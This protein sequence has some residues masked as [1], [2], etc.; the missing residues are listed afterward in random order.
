MGGSPSY[1]LPSLKRFEE[2]SETSM[3]KLKTISSRNSDAGKYLK[4]FLILN[5]SC[6]DKLFPIDPERKVLFL[7]HQ[8]HMLDIKCSCCCRRHIQKISPKN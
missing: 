1:S 6:A 8:H 7:W 5:L 3:N 2:I 4:I